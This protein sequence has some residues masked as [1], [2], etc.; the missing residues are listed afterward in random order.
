MYIMLIATQS[1]VST[2]HRLNTRKEIISVSE[3]SAEKNQQLSW[4]KAKLY[5][6]VITCRLCTLAELFGCALRV[7]VSVCNTVVRTC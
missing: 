6:T 4:D 1:I 7:T 3:M 5:N 2:T